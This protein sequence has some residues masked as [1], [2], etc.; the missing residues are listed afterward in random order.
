MDEET[1]VPFQQL[2][3]AQRAEMATSLRPLV[4][5]DGLIA[6]TII[7][8]EVSEAWLDEIWQPGTREALTRD[9]AKRISGHADDHFIHVLNEL[10][11]PL[12]AFEP[13]FEK[14]QS[15][16]ANAHI[17]AEG[18]RRGI[19]LAGEG[20][21]PIFDDAGARQM[22][23][24]IFLLLP[25]DVLTSAELQDAG[26]AELTPARRE[27]MLHTTLSILPD[28]IVGLHSVSLAFEAFMSEGRIAAVP[29][30]KV[31]RNEPCPCGSGKKFKKCCIDFKPEPGGIG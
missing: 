10:M 17:W 1:Y 7:S 16:I 14:T 30:S 3:V 25:D 24:A 13:Y 27:E 21:A 22:T 8:T 15:P 9:A 26:L 5:L 11:S 23:M 20:W 4:W 31:G 2:T 19:Q 29:R 12:P 28:L 18:F 6:A